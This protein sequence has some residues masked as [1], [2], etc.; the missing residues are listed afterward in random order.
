MYNVLIN[1]KKSQFRA[2]VKWIE[3]NDPPYEETD[4]YKIFELPFKITRDSKL[5]WLQFQ[6]L[7][8][9]LP[10]N[11]YL[12]KLKLIESPNCSFC[13]ENPET[14]DHL[15]V[16]CYEVK[17]LWRAVEDLFLRQYRIPITF[18]RQNIIFGKNKECKKNTVPNL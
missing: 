3:E 14:I 2:K 9:I 8:R 16:E 6:T 15:F 11:Y 4:W 5:Q 10:T 17:K 7:H 1:E 18:D 13:G 12:H